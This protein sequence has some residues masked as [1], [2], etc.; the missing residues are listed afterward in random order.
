MHR[1]PAASPS[2]L[3]LPEAVPGCS[4]TIACRMEQCSL[5]SLLLKGARPVATLLWQDEQEPINP[6]LGVQVEKVTKFGYLAMLDVML[7]PASDHDDADPPPG[8]ATGGCSERGEPC[9][10]AAA[11][12]AGCAASHPAVHAPAN[13]ADWSRHC[14]LA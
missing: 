12:V 8:P 10:A 11:A 13:A 5:A 14:S 6:T 9:D 1:L 4:A 3:L 2:T 7:A